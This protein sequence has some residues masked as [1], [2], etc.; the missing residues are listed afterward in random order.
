[1]ILLLS[2]TFFR[3]DPKIQELKKNLDTTERRFCVATLTIMELWSG[4][5]LS[6]KSKQEKENILQF[7][8]S[9]EIL[10]LTQQAAF[11]AGEIEVQLLRSGKTI[12]PED[13]MIA[14]I[15]RVNNETIVTG[16]RHFSFIAGLK[17]LTY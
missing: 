5:C 9:L 11:E 15:A 13:C 14:A 2:L 16:D 8:E 17:V 12:D 6:P 3:G 10:D 7:L 4:A 1:M